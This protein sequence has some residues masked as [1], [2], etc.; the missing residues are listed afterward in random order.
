[1]NSTD[2]VRINWTQSTAE[3]KLVHQG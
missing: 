3:I 2:D 1:M